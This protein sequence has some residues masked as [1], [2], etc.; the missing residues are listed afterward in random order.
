MMCCRAR[1]RFKEAG[2]DLLVG[3]LVEVDTGEKVIEKVYSRKNRLVRPPVAN[4]DQVVVVM[5]VL[6]PPL[7]L[8]FLDRILISAGASFLNIIICLNKMD[9]AA[10]RDEERVKE[11]KEVF[12]GCGYRVILSSAV[13][14]HGIDELRNTLQGKITVL[15]G[16]SGTGKSTLINK[17]KPELDLLSGA[18]ST[19]TERGRH[20]TRHVELLRLDN[21]AFVVDTPGFQRLD[22][23]GISSKELYSFFPEISLKGP[24]RFNSCLHNDEPGCAV[25]DAVQN[26]EIASW[27]Y[28]HYLAFLKEV[29]QREKTFFNK[30]GEDTK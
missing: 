8:V 6:R 9:L 30:K 16:P 26:G 13:T 20:T 21:A 10:A 23:K 15:A 2:I 22:L 25:K 1:G 14:G 27:R 17:L 19:K 5:S 29:H 3:D 28:E 11:V 7:D 24:C 18:V 12:L 4:V